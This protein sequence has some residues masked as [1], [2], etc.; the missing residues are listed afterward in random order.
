MAKV[1]KAIFDVPNKPD[2]PK[3]PPPPPPPPPDKEGE[4][5]E[6]DVLRREKERKGRKATVLT[7]S[8][9]VEGGAPTKKKTLL[10]Q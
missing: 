7:G 5:S 1:V 2:K 6:E 3:P 4:L 8:R 9:G 10:G